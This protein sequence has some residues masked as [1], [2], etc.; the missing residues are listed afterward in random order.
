MEPITMV[1]I[2]IFVLWLGILSMGKYNALPNSRYKWSS[3][4]PHLIIGNCARLLVMVSTAAIV[5]HMARAI[6]ELGC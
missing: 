6:V 1:L 4:Y 3:D 2:F 5:Y